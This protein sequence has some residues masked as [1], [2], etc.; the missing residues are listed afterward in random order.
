MWLLIVLIFELI[1][2][3]LLSSRLTQTY[4]TLFYRL[5][6][7]QNVAIGLLTCMYLPGTIVHELAHLLFAEILRVPTGDITFTPKI[8]KI[9][10]NTQEIKLGGV[11]IGQSDPFRRFL[12][13]IAPVILG[14]FFLFL[15]VWLFQKFWPDIKSELWYYQLGF[16]VLISYLLFTLSNGMFSSPK[17]MEGAEYVIPV[18]ILIILGL[19]FA[20]VRIN[21][22]PELTLNLTHIVSGLA[23]AFGIVVGI[24]GL[25][26]LINITLLK[27]FR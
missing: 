8:E 25:V 9:H 14:V 23:K 15:V 27:L 13:G 16:I 1:I 22:T 2:L 24:N 26:L 5:F 11:K 21:L 6:K 17:D 7:N 20:G 4:Y 12:I 10:G 19:Y 3:F 18:L